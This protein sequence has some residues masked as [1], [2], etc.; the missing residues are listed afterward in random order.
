MTI[1]Q[2]WKPNTDYTIGQIVEFNNCFYKCLQHHNSQNLY[3]P[4]SY[5]N[6][7]WSDLPEIIN[8]NYSCL[9]WFSGMYYFPNTRV[10]FDNRAYICLQSHVAGPFS[11]PTQSKHHWQSIV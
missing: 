5:N 4:N 3:Y 8:T 1:H 11:S 7:L 6:V 2:D 10:V 9:P